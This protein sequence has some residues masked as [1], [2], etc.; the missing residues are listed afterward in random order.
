[1]LPFENLSNIYSRIDQNK[2]RRRRRAAFM[3]IINLKSA[4][5]ILYLVRNACICFCSMWEAA[6]KDLHTKKKK[7]FKEKC[8]VHFVTAAS[9]QLI[10]IFREFLLLCDDWIFGFLL[11]RAAAA[12]Y[13]IP[14]RVHRTI[15]ISSLI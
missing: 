7:C 10:F 2:F 11:R 9:A 8:V 3:L 12:S 5:L 15:L 14:M 13:F 4:Y 6:A 1:M